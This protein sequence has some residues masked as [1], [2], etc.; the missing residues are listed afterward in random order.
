VN[1][2]HKLRDLLGKPKSTR[3]LEDWEGPVPSIGACNICN[4]PAG[5]FGAT[6]RIFHELACLALL[7]S[8]EHPSFFL[9]FLSHHL[10]SGA[11]PAYSLPFQLQSWDSWPSPHNHN[12]GTAMSFSVLLINFSLDY[13]LLMLLQ[14][15]ISLALHFEMDLSPSPFTGSILESQNNRMVS[16]GRDLKDHLVSTPPVM[17]RIFSTA[18]KF[19]LVLVR[20][21]GFS[22]FYLPLFS[23]ISL[24]YYCVRSS[25]AWFWRFF[26]TTSSH[27]KELWVAICVATVSSSSKCQP[28]W[29]PTDVT[30]SQ[31]WGCPWATT[32]SCC[33]ASH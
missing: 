31:T 33:P 2:R 27:Y 4:L 23:L 14:I 1:G 7:S 12:L 10:F 25:P 20:L 30:D 6:A 8:P 11:P 22:W 29:L 24:L 26:G 9:P 16:V 3:Q 5:G 18:V 28:F 17:H 32:K 13:E 21:H 19:C 15:V